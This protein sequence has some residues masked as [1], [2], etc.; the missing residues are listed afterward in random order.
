MGST[1]PVRTSVLEHGVVS[2]GV[3]RWERR[4]RM[5][6]AAAILERVVWRGLTRNDELLDLANNCGRWDMA[7]LRCG[8][9]GDG[10]IAYPCLVCNKNRGMLA[11][12]N[13]ALRSYNPWLVGTLAFKT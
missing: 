11:T 1:M 4:S 3:G 8:R 12:S 6:P 13:F 9:R 5:D 10:V 2:D 7:I